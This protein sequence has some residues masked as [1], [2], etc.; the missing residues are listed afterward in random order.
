MIPVSLVKTSESY[1]I[2]L[3]TINWQTLYDSGILC[4]DCGIIRSL[5]MN[6]TG[7]ADWVTVTETGGSNYRIGLDYAGRA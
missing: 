7:F 1:A 6:H 2:S 4:Q 5:P 3:V